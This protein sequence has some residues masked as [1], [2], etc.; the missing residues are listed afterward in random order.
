MGRNKQQKGGNMGKHQRHWQRHEN[1]AA[2]T[3]VGGGDSDRVFSYEHKPC[4]C[5]LS[6]HFAFKQQRGLH[7]PGLCSQQF[8]VAA[9]YLSVQRRR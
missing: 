5:R 9:Y 4:L 3:V 2:L 7:K 1:D 8:L 6:L